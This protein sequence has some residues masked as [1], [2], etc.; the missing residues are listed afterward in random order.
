MT[1]VP[2]SVPIK[3]KPSLSRKMTAMITRE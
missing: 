2:M 3:T 1:F